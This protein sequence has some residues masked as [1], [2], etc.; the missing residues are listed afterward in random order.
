MVRQDSQYLTVDEA[1]E[2]LRLAPD[3]VRVKIRNG[4][5]IRGTHYFTPRGMRVR[6][7]R[8]AL[9]K[10]LE[11]DSKPVD[12]PQADVIPMARGYILG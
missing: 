12:K 11:G 8:V 5:F 7:K 1:A 4:D 10:W 6:F 9:I 2:L 3:T